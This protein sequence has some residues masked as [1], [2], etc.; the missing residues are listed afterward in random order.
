MGGWATQ[1][2]WLEFEG[3]GSFSGEIR[4]AD[5]FQLIVKVDDMDDRPKALSL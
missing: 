4:T 3:D 1:G 5:D 2:P